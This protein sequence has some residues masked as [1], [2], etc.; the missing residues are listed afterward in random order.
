MKSQMFV[1]YDSKANAYMQPWFLTTKPMAIRAFTDCIADPKHNFGAHPE[2]YTLF[3][4]GT[5]DSQS[6]KIHWK[7]PVSLGNGLQYVRQDEPKT[8]SQ[9]FAELTKPLPEDQT[10]KDMFGM[11]LNPKE[12]A[13]QQKVDGET[14]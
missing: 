2:D 14:Q 10:Q 4:I 8:E 9:V 12:H 3:D 13:E 6:A 5:F 7:T 1:I 11:G